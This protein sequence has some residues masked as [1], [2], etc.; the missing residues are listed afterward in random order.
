MDQ[1]E[2]DGT[3]LT[4]A[5]P[6]RNAG[7]DALRAALT[8]LVVFHHT[9]ITYGAIGGWFYREVPTDG[10]IE[11]KFLIFFCA[12]NQAYFMGLF[13]LIAGY[14]TPGA[15][16]RHG[17]VRYLA[18][19]A[20]RLG[21]P[22]LV[23][24]YIIGPATV[25][26]AG[27][28]NGDAFWRTLIV[29][30]ERG[31]FI[32]GPLWFAQALLIFSVVYVVWRAV[33]GAGRPR[34]F[35]SNLALAAAALLTGA[36]AFSLRLVWPVGV[37]VLGLQLGY[38]ASY[39]V[40]FA[41]GCAGAPGC[42][43]VAVPGRQRRLWLWV[44]WISLPVLPAALL[45]APHVPMFRGNSSGGWNFA[46]ALYAFWEPLVAWGFCLGLLHY[47][48]RRFRIVG[49]VWRALSRR[50]YAIYVLHPPVLVGISLAWR[51]VQ[52]PHLLKFA[53]TGTAACLACYALA[54]MLLRAAPIRRAL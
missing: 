17:A 15:V 35:P 3:A 13:F 44:A 32:N 18:E 33:A 1:E 47:F 54:G 26:L 8:L 45:L 4:D 50:A 11:T 27:L 19:R 41:A 6:A 23:F 34:P 51:Q 48:G 30:W 29:L 12:I 2:G 39:T 46:A 28:A 20:R 42:W 38:F 21:V 40:L 31:R 22:L 14:F 10:R 7:I 16:A 5:A 53:V 43:L 9:A 24:G 37:N 36:A 52:A 25:A 49:P